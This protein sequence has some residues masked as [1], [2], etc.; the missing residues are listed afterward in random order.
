MLDF[1]VLSSERL[2]SD[3]FGHPVFETRRSE[4]GE[5]LYKLKYQSDNSVVDLLVETAANF[6]E[7]WS[8][9]AELIA[10][11]PASKSRFMQPVSLL[12]EGLGQ[13]LN[14]PC[15]DTCIQRNREVPE[16]KNVLDYDERLQLLT[17]AYDVNTGEVEGRK[18]L[19]IDDLYRS[20]ATMNAAADAL[21]DIG[22]AVDVY[23]LAFTRTKSRQ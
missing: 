2:G 6:V 23:A 12:G 4:V 13:K 18:I 8:P 20:G 11:V 3:E 7:G 19:L 9:G 17:G 22:R 1:H 5:L 14:L 10:L 21:Y 16:L 15:R